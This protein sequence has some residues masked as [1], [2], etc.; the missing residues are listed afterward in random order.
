MVFWVRSG[1]DTNLRLGVVASKKVGAAVARNR[2]R[3]RLREAYRQYRYQLSGS[4]DVVLVARRSI[5]EASAEQ[6]QALAARSD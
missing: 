2:A 3:R 1:A 4:C 5:G 6:S